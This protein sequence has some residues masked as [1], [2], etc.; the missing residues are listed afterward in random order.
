[1]TQC[2]IDRF[3]SKVDRSG[4][5]D[6]CWPWTAGCSSNGYG[7]FWLAGKN[8]GAHCVALE[9]HEGRPLGPGEHALHTCDHKPCCNGRHL[10]RGTHAANMADRNAKGRQATG[11]RT[12]PETRARG[13]RNGARLHPERLA[14]G[15]RHWSRTHPERLAR[16]KRNGAHTHPERMPR[17]PG[18]R[19][20]R[21]KLTTEQ[22]TTIRGRY[23]A[24]GVSL[25]ALALE[26]GVNHS[27]IW[28]IV[29]HKAWRHLILP[30]R[31]S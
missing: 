1:M 26:Y 9:L 7:E 21:A 6:A 24:R 31:W 23:A 3:W 28:T 10:F 11:E 2:D 17:R 30:L 29:R 4:G 22:V 27:V 20:A 12:H 5:P 25:R 13:D 15:D 18:E 16:G 8:R 19:N 14:R